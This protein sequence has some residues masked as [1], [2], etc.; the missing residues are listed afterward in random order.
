MISMLRT[1]SPSD[2]TNGGGS[3]SL[4]STS[5]STPRR[6]N[7]IA[8][9][10]PVGPPPA[11]ITSSM[12][13]PWCAGS[14]GA[15]APRAGRAA[16]S[17]EAEAIAVGG[18]GGLAGGAGDL[19]AELELAQGHVAPPVVGAQPVQHGEHVQRAGVAVRGAHERVDRVGA[20]RAAVDVPGGAA[21]ADVRGG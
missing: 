18:E 12:R 16:R 3:A 5:T 9:I 21:D 2:R 11:M 1:C 7:S 8:S 10:M 17:A 13:P 6:R 4:S 15:G 14:R 20:V 19:V